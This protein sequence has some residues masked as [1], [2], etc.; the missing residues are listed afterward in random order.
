M[1][2]IELYLETV[3]YINKGLICTLGDTLTVSNPLSEIF[4]CRDFTDTFMITQIMTVTLNPFKR[5][6]WQGQTIR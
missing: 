1:A 4:H 6:H 2:E 5:V 3:K